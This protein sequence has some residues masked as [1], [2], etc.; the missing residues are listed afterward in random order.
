MQEN[1]QHSDSQ[2]VSTQTLW[3]FIKRLFGITRKNYPG[4]FWGLIAT[5]SVVAVA[6]AYFPYLWMLYIDDLITPLFI[7][8]QQSVQNQTDFELQWQQFLPFVYKYGG[9]ML[10][11]GLGVLAFIWCAENIRERIIYDLRK[12]MF[13]K[14][15]HLSFSFY[16]KSSA[17]WLVSRITS[18]TDRVT[19][20][21]SWGF[22]S[23]VWG[24]SMVLICFGIMFYIEW[25]LA[26]LVLATF[27]LLLYV[28]VKIR[29][30]VLKYSRKA[31]KQNSDMI[32]YVTEHINGVAVNKTTAQEENASLGYN[33]KTDRM[34]HYS[35]KSSFYTAMYM[36]LV[37]LTGSI[38]AGF[39]I[40]YG[41]NV[42][43]S[44]TA[45]AFTLGAWAAFFG[46]SRFIFEPIFDISRFYALAQDSLSAGERIFSLIDEKVTIKDAAGATDFEKIKGDIEFRNVD[47]HYHPDK[48]ILQHF[49]LTI[50]A[51]Q[52]VALVGP[53]GHGKT[54]LTALISRFYEP[55]GGQLLIDGEDYT[56]KTLQSL[57]NQ[58]G[59]ILQQPHLFSGTVLENILYGTDDKNEQKAIET[60]KLIGA[61]NLLAKLYEEVG[62][63][64]KNLSNGE[65]QLVSFARAAIKEPAILVMDEAT[66]SVDTLSEIQ[67]QKGIEKLIENRTS[68]VI[69]HRLSTIRHCDKIVVIEHGKIKEMGS[70]EELI[71]NKGHY[72]DLY[73]KQARAIQVG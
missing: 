17:G 47:F 46:Y 49:N 69:A 16:D 62:E 67:I 10:T 58:L 22:V 21:I 53:T 15:Q 48:K 59:I 30:L 35:F 6:D 36:P 51:G 2:F 20:L 72:Y 3:P 63:E 32:A 73:L 68:I 29:L 38:A 50:E 42:D 45:G 40:L 8:W 23:F 26:L 24:I 19:E 41:A 70:H 12:S 43:M 4:L 7:E 55:T 14:L 28:S 61:E 18:D 5:V 27:P 11:M 71:A 33:E 66:S 65:R 52:S 9:W 25:K 34:R 60:L 64:G 39:V 57:R 56:Q 37:F 54:T 44:G 31:R 13:D 1:H